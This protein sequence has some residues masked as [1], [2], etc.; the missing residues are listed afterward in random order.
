MLADEPT[1]NLDAE[2]G[3]E[4]LTLLRG[5]NASDGLTIVMVTHDDAIAKDADHTVRLENGRI[6]NAK[7][8]VVA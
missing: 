8:A 1:G 3:H 5:L 2:T 6:A 4:I 7:L